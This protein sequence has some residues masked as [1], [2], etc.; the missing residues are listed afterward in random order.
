[1]T[2]AKRQTEAR[3][4][5]VRALEMAPPWIVRALRKLGWTPPAERFH[6][7]R[8]E[9]ALLTGISERHISR[10][11]KSEQFP[12]VDATTG[13]WNVQEVVQWCLNRHTA[14]E[15]ADPMMCGNGQGS[16]ALEEYRR[17]KAREAKRRND[18]EEAMLIDAATVTV[19]LRAIGATFK[20]EAEALARVHGPEIGA[21]IAEMVDRVQQAFVDRLGAEADE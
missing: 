11:Q 6:C 17:E 5:M 13:K 4:A 10:V 15:D 18:A 14:P 16:P 21:E 1:M 7:S 3:A 9:V 19:E 20:A 12:T 8:K 2:V